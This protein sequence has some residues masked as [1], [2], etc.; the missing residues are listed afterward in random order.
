MTATTKTKTYWDPGVC[1]QS[2]DPSPPV[3][4]WQ[5]RSKSFYIQQTIVQGTGVCYVS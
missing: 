5:P 1:H 2:T 3:T 4:D